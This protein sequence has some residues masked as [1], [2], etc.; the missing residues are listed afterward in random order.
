MNQILLSFSNL[1]YVYDEVKVSK[2]LCRLIY[3]L[4]IVLYN[5]CSRCTKFTV[6]LYFALFIYTAGGSP[7][8]MY[9]ILGFVSCIH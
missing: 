2:F 8:Y 3:K 6:T 4:P 7:Y 5:C 1:N 9:A